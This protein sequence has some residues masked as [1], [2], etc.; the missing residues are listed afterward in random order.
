[1][2]TKLL[3]EIKLIVEKANL[4]ELEND[5][6][7]V[8]NSLSEAG[9]EADAKKVA[10]ALLKKVNECAS[11]PQ[12]RRDSV[13]PTFTRNPDA[14][15]FFINLGSFDGLT[16][17]TLIEFVKNNVEG[18]TTEDFSDSFIKDKF[19]FFE[20]PK[21]KADAVLG[22]MNGLTY[23]E[24][25]VHVELSEKKPA[26]QHRDGGFRGGFRGGRSD[27]RRDSFSHDR[28]YSNRGGRR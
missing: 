18:L 28:S 16:P 25:E 8:L 2:E 13:R 21:D 1:M 14:Q 11:A 26:S 5:I 10:A 24:R 4:E 19:A 22:K 12:N 7:T 17:S 9:I 20:L 15:R 3:E 27:S 23:N 6:D